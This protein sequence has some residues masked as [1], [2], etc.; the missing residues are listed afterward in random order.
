MRPYNMKLNLAKWIFSINVGKFL[1]FMVTQRGIEV[2]PTQ[3]KTVL[4]TPTPS[5][6]KELQRFMGRLVILGHF[7]TYLINKLSPFFVTL[8]ETSTFG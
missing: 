7:I 8:K 5:S 2:N 3:M 1:G 6:K 4:E